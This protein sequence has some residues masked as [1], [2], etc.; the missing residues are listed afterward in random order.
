MNHQS[1]QSQVCILAV[2]IVTSQSCGGDEFVQHL[3]EGTHIVS[4]RSL[5]T[6]QYS[7]GFYLKAF[8]FKAELEKYADQ[9]AQLVERIYK[10]GRR[11][12]VYEQ[13]VLVA[14]LE[15]WICAELD[16]PCKHRVS[17]V[18]SGNNLNQNLVFESTKEALSCDGMVSPT[19]SLKRFD[20]SLVGLVSEAF[21]ITGEGSVVGAT[22]ASGNVALIQ[23]MRS[24]R[25]GYCDVCLVVG[26]ITDYSPVDLL[27]LYNIGAMTG[28]V[29]QESDSEV[30]RPFDENRTGFI[31]G[32]AAACVILTGDSWESQTHSIQIQ[33]SGGAVALDANSRA[34][35][36][37]LG[38]VAAI[39]QALKDASLDASQVNYVNAHGTASILGDETELLA[40]E[41]V[42]GR[43]ID[44]LTVNSTKALTGHCMSSAGVVEAIAVYFQMIHSF[45][46]P[47]PNLTHPISKNVALVGKVAELMPIE[48]AVSNSFAFGGI[49]TALVFEKMIM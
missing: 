40:L 3:K 5:F 22:S 6:D 47:N 23:G 17:F 29:D 45:A 30:C 9:N 27:S 8:P 35:P 20:T 18:I 43:S 25:H 16:Y 33:L 39:Q 46:H 4:A 37:R 7:Y 28:I 41:S 42:F 12:S 24:I 31:P 26:A 36:D 49:N 34:N 11:A 38:E 1:A 32:Q 15:A 14:I 19:Y 10:V 44:K 13:A 21:Q 48:F 2:G